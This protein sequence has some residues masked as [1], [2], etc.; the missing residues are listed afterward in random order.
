MSNVSDLILR[1]GPFAS[2]WIAGTSADKLGKKMV[3]AT[4]IEDIV[5]Q[6]LENQRINL[7][8]RVS[9]MLLKGLVVVYSKKLQYMLTDCEDMITK[10]KLSF[11][12]SS[13][14]K[15]SKTTRE[16]LITIRTD[17]S[18]LT[19]EP[20]VD[21][22]EWAKSVNPEEYFVLDHP[23]ISFHT[24]ESSQVSTDIDSQP[25]SSLS[26]QADTPMR[27]HFINTDLG[28][29]L[30]TT[31]VKPVQ[32][33]PGYEEP[34]A[35]WDDDD[36]I[37]IPDNDD[38]ENPHPVFQGQ[39]EST[40]ES[41]APSK[42]AATTKKSVLTID[43]RIQLNRQRQAS[44]SRRP[45]P[46]G[47]RSLVTGNSQFDSLFADSRKAAQEREDEAETTLAQRPV[48]SDD[49][50][51]IG[52]FVEDGE[53]GEAEVNR[54]AAAAAEL[55]DVPI[56]GP[57]S[58]SDDFETSGLVTPARKLRLAEI[59]SPFPQYKFVVEQTPKRT[60]ED[61]I[62][63]QTIGTLKKFQEALK[64]DQAEKGESVESITFS[65]TCAGS[66][67][68]QAARVFYQLLVLKSTGTIDVKQEEPF[69]EIVISPGK[70]FWSA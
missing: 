41:E 68:R 12:P 51:G 6:I 10:I 1:K 13:I 64:A 20:T 66:N 18:D 48:D 8:L 39:A 24:A 9:G 43:R 59:E 61:S 19:I 52:G 22:S 60:I 21:I 25:N 35:N 33:R 4:D 42:E 29:S 63:S 62:T 46:S 67:R 37:P 58:G 11:N 28:D 34:A 65:R 30:A 53:I 17:I 14:D 31:P 3:L 23:K 49:D 32:T 27:L 2:V 44:R 45:D 26:S 38:D 5:K 69:G 57:D 50:I 15:D 56:P 47:K 16:D 54:S 40:S 36:D 7:V 70:K 55:S